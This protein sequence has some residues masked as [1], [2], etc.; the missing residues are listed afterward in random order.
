MPVIFNQSEIDSIL[1]LPI[2]A[3]KKT[4]MV[5]NG[6][7]K[8]TTDLPEEIKNTLYETLGLDIR[9]KTEI[10]MR[11]I[12]GDTTAHADR[13][14]A[15]EFDN[16]YLVYL[17]DSAGKFCIGDE[18]HTIES[19]AAYIFQEGVRHWTEECGSE[20]RL[21][22]GPMSEE[23]NAVG[24]AGIAGEGG[25]S[26]Y[27]RQIEGTI[28]SSNNQNDWYPLY[29]PSYINNTDTSKGI[30]KIIFITDITLSN[31][32]DY[33][34]CGSDNIQIGSELLNDD[35]SIPTITISDVSD[36]LGFIQNGQNGG[37]G[38]NNISIY[39]LLIH[40]DNTTLAYGAGWVGWAYF[41]NGANNILIKNCQ[42]DGDI[43]ENSGGILGEY[44]ATNSNDFT[45]DGCSSKGEISTTD[46]GAGGICG[47]RCADNGYIQIVRCW[48]SGIIHTGG[49][50]IIGAS[51]AEN[52]TVNIS[53]SY[54]TGL[55]GTNAGGIVSRDTIGSVIVENSYSRGNIGDAAGGIF[56]R[57]AS[58]GSHAINCYSSGS[59]SLTL[60][61]GIFGANYDPSATATHCYTSGEGDGGGI[62]S[63]D[64]SDTSTCYSETNNANAGWT[65]TNAKATLTGAPTTTSYGENWAQLDGLN[66]A[67]I[68]ATSGYSPFSLTVTD[69][70]I[71]FTLS[72]GSRTTPALVPG[73]THSIVSINNLT[74]DS[75]PFITI[76]S[77][78]GIITV[79]D[80]AT[81]GSIYTIVV[82]S[83]KNPYSFTNFSIT[84]IGV[85]SETNPC[86][87]GTLVL[88]G[89]DYE[90]RNKIISGNTIIGDTSIRRT[91]YSSYS[92]FYYN[93]K[94]AY[95]SKRVA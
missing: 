94:I 23:G 40:S 70:T 49:G 85:T 92:Y 12:K 17:T 59:I 60:G 66:T 28:E 63:G 36:Y 73:Y 20:P 45:V 27:I 10:P 46:S 32:Y 54:S 72:P 44:A 95:A 68:V 39:N 53:Q 76:D 31:V 48:S 9:S 14:I 43:R 82:Y 77:S 3:D 19:G 90:E 42:S 50:G 83:T 7:I 52:G 15:G 55:I 93:K 89:I 21:L 11:W 4:E 13:S 26:I 61:G 62:F 79:G 69:T 16:T 78:T 22:L 18:R 91:P 86:C 30:L 64:S 51:S 6:Q 29:F 25:T 35:G 88:K 1:S 8:F 47:Q 37:N 58:A 41:G 24:Y 5:G 75:F 71:T 87:T 57:F 74:P 56:G 38:F 33:F 81:V 80:G 84:I 67:Y 65:D 34:I 2:V